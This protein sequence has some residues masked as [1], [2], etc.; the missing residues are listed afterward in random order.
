MGEQEDPLVSVHYV[1]GFL[2]DFDSLSDSPYCPI[3]FPVACSEPFPV[4][5]LVQLCI[6]PQD[7]N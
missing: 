1:L 4:L 2:Q 5:F 7:F 6:T 3:R